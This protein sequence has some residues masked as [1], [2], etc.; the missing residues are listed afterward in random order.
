MPMTSISDRVAGA[1]LQAYDFGR[2]ATVVDVA[3][4]RGA[5]LAAILAR[6]P[7][8]R[9]VLFDQPHVVAG[10]HL[11]GVEDRCDIVGGNMFVEVPAGG[12][13]YVMKAILNDWEDP[14]AQAILQACRR[15]VPGS[16]ALLVVERLLDSA[17][18]NV[19]FADL[20]M[21]VGPGGL[22]RT[23][24][25]YAEL[26]GAAGFRLTRTVPTATEWV[27]VEAVPAE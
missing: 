9:G 13:A 23:T 27:V 19:A 22:E 3:G 12:D 11:A 18:Q 8:M 15:V 25:E 2:F 17:D 20:N 1:I 10:V 24:G 5:L 6:H 4:G 21:M 16:G 7:A 14:Q 26:F